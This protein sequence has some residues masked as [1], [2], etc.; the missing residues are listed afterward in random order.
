M[1]PVMTTKIEPVYRRYLLRLVRAYSRLSGKGLGGISWL[2]YGDAKWLPR[3]VNGSNDR[4]TF[5]A[6]DRAVAWFT[7]NWPKDSTM[8]VLIDPKH[9]Q[10]VKSNGTKAKT[11]RTR[12]EERRREE[13]FSSEG[14]EGKI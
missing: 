13:K 8:P 1:I 12:E 4:L 14:R 10:K 11:K 2:I 7:K 5:R 6:Y 3:I 9:K